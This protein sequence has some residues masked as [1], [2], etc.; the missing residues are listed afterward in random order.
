MQV[1]EITGPTHFLLRLRC[2]KCP[3]RCRLISIEPH[4]ALAAAEIHKFQCNN[5]GRERELVLP[6]GS[7]I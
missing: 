5:C 6:L 4:P 7:S 3:G 2:I 1:Q